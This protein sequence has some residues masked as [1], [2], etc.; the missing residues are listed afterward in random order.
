MVVVCFST[1][2]IEEMCNTWL[3]PDT[4]VYNGARLLKL[5]VSSQKAHIQQ[6]TVNMTQCMLFYKLHPAVSE[7]LR[8]NEKKVISAFFPINRESIN[9]SE[10]I[11]HVVS[12]TS[13]L[14]QGITY[15][16]H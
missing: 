16:L 3:P 13:R 7:N 14:P 11:S 4:S 2:Q 6:V 8:I 12:V 5:D 1:D 15:T 10:S 9:T